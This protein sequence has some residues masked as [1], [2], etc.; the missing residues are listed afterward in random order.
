MSSL[1][2]CPSVLESDLIKLQHQMKLIRN[3]FL[4]QQ[5]YRQDHFSHRRFDYVIYNGTALGTL[6][7]ECSV[8]PVV[9]ETTY[10]GSLGL[11]VNNPCD[12]CGC[13]CE[14]FSDLS[15][16]YFSLDPVQANTAEN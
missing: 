8:E 14:D 1:T 13:I 12:M 2:V 4:S 11:P 6:G 15:E 5:T 3:F 7:S 16:R 10:K 9:V